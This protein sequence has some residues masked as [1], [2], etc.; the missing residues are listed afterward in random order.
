M[1]T[2]LSFE[3][4][5]EIKKLLKFETP[6]AKIGILLGRS[7]SCIGKEVYR[8]G[9]IT[10]YDPILSQKSSDERK[11]IADEK[12]RKNVITNPF[13]ALRNRVDNL[14]FQLEILTDIIKELKANDQKD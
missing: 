8:N 13:K 9:G 7:T 3:E 2:K 4:R 6:Y 5:K 12:R 1:R 10:K 11:L 14:E